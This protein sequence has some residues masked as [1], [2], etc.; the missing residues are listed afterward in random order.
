ML[1]SLVWG[2]SDGVGGSLKASWSLESSEALPSRSS[3]SQLPVAGIVCVDEAADVRRRGVPIIALTIRRC[4]RRNCCLRGSV[5][6]HDSAPYIIVGM[7]VPRY[8]RSLRLSG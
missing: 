2:G 8:S 7:T 5:I 3:L 1:S 6:V 4:V